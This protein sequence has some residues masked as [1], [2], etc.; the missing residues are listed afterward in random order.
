MRVRTVTTSL[1]SC[2]SFFVTHAADIIRDVSQ[3]R[4]ATVAW[5]ACTEDLKVELQLTGILKVSIYFE[6]ELIMRSR[7]L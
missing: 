6:T 1:I 4:I 2:H 3:C 7:A 5:V